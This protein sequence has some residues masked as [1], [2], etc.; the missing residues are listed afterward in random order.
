MHFSDL[1]VHGH[2]PWHSG[3]SGNTQV[4]KNCAVFFM[5]CVVSCHQDD[6]LS[7]NA[8]VLFARNSEQQNFFSMIALLPL[9]TAKLLLKLNMSVMDKNKIPV[10]KKK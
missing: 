9:V 2:D 6:I 4:L 5:L 3:G 7:W 10:R 8:S 1:C